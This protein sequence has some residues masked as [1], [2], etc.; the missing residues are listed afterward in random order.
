MGIV[1]LIKKAYSDFELV[2]GDNCK[3]KKQQLYEIVQLALRCHYTPD[4]YYTYRFY[5]K[6]IKYSD[7][8]NYLS[9]YYFLEYLHPT[10]NSSE[11]RVILDNKLLFN[12]YF[13]RF[14]LPVSNICGY[15]EHNVGFRFDG[16]PLNR[17]E[18]FRNLISE[19]M[20]SSLVVKPVGGSQGK[21]ILVFSNIE[22]NTEEIK[23]NSVDRGRLTLDEVLVCLHKE[24]ESKK[25]AGFI[26]EERIN[27]VDLL[28]N[29]N[30]DSLNTVR[31]VTLMS[32]E[33]QVTFPLAVLRVGRSGSAVDNISR[34]GLIIPLDIESGILSGKGITYSRFGK[35]LHS[36]HPDSAVN[37]SGLLVPHWDEVKTL[38]CQAAMSF[39]FCRSVGWD[40]AVTDQGP[41]LI[42]GNN[43]WAIDL[44]VNSGGFLQPEV[45]EILAGYGLRFPQNNLP[46]INYHDLWRAL[47]RW[48]SKARV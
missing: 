15:Y 42:E 40:V 13:R 32:N 12:I 20:P 39:P 27:Q 26:L 31:L 4:E 16:L 48:S 45:R 22:Y 41:I 2:D 34:G 33:R 18:H 38:C 19:L 8:L 21:D 46:R 5:E 37:F 30:T 25:Y 3:S 28:N 14:N 23:F 47:K 1:K 43:F 10:L 7:M 11:W 6:D 9:N 24:T 44:Q 17:P 35:G 36:S 29:L